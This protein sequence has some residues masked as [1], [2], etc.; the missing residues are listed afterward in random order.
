M[1]IAFII[2]IVIFMVPT[3][4]LLMEGNFEGAFAAVLVVCSIAGIVTAAF[5]L[6]MFLK[7]GEEPGAQVII[8]LLIAAG[9]GGGAVAMFKGQRRR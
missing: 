5:G 4:N 9:C 7:P 1:A 8:G 6:L 2:V 3:F